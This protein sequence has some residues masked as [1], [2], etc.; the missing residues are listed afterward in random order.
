MAVQPESDDVDAHEQRD[1]RNGVGIDA[2][3]CSYLRR[4]R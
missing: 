3:E 1:H 2:L 4:S